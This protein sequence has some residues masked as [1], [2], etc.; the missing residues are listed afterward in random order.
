[1][2]LAFKELGN[3]D[4]LK[5]FVL[6]EDHAG[7]DSL[8]W[9][10]FGTSF[11]INCNTAG[12]GKNILFDAATFAE[13][14][15]HNMEILNLDPKRDIDMLALSHCHFDHTGGLVGMVKAIDKQNIPIIV[16]PDIF[17][18]VIEMETG[19]W[20]IGLTTENTKENIEKEGG[21]WILSKEP[22]KLASGV[23]TSGE[24]E[25]G[26]E[27]K[28]TLDSYNLEAGR[29]V[30]DEILDDM[31]LYLNTK[32]GLVIVTSCSHAGI[33]N[34]VKQGIKLTG[35]GKVGAVIGGYHLVDADEERVKLTVKTLK[36]LGVEKIITGHC[37]GLKAEATFLASFGEGFEEL[38]SGK[39]IRF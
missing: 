7:Y 33:V 28:V 5:I 29:L 1:M 14:I 22:M 39:I 16:H 10:Q 18:T 4:D 30:K 23:M 11:L 26:F 37:T 21:K 38:Y 2:E 24:I 36:D 20:S 3:V 17:R 6:A 25:R 19:V 35:Q 8:F 32:E 34:I 13:P 12:V 15:L 27:K 31:S 9:A